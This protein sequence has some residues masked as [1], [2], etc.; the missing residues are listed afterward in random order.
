VSEA[1]NMGELLIVQRAYGS[2]STPTST[3]WYVAILISD[4]VHLSFK[5]IV[6]YRDICRKLFKFEIIGNDRK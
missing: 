5:I 2:L 4:S 3:S 6:A 1:R